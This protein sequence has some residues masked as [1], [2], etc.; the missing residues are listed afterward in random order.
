MNKEEIITKLK[1]VK[2]A[3]DFRERN[4]LIF[5]AQVDEETEQLSDLT[6]EE[7][8]LELELAKIEEEELPTK[9]WSHADDEVDNDR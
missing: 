3:I 8:Q 6:L 2:N 1:I 7:S 4:R 9:P 5:Q